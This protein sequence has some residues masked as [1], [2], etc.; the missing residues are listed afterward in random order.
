MLKD[1]LAVLS[2]RGFHVSIILAFS[3]GEFV[4]FASFIIGV[5]I[6]LNIYFPW[7]ESLVP[8]TVSSII[9]IIIMG[10]SSPT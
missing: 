10:H 1:V 6:V 7:F 2:T 8:L 9:V 3:F 5:F 4:H